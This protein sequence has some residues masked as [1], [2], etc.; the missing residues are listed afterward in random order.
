M[1]VMEVST[2]GRL[3]QIH[4]DFR[5][6]P[7]GQP[8]SP[9]ANDA[10]AAY[11]RS[12]GVP[13][14]AYLVRYESMQPPLFYLA[15]GAL[16]WPF[17]TNPEAVLYISKLTAA[18]FGAIAI[19]FIWA[20][21]RQL[22]PGKPEL[23]LLV[24]VCGA[25]LP[26]FAYGSAS[27]N[28]DTALFAVG[29]AS[30]YVW[31]RGLRELGYDRFLL[32]A[33]ALIGLGLLA[34]LTMLALVPAFALVVLFR[35]LQAPGNWNA[36]LRRLMLLTSTSAAAALAVAGWWLVRNLLEYGEI[37]GSA[38]ALKWYALHYGHADLSTPAGIANFI[39]ATMV[40]FIGLFGWD[41]TLF[42]TSVNLLAQAVVVTLIMLTGAA[43]ARYFTGR[44]PTTKEAARDVLIL[45]VALAGTIA[46]YV[47]FN[48]GVS[49]QPQARYL[50]V[51]LLPILLALLGGLYTFTRRSRFAPFILAALPFTLLL[52]NALAIQM[53]STG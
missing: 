31:L 47:Q 44:N 24:A 49:Y 7:S 14:G 51:A 27:A 50:F 52:L 10:V 19:Y 40:S 32:K 43:L 30:F 53:L 37:S 41:A 22:A 29:A 18:L 5:T 35:A 17:S 3:P 46:T 25:L 39:S 45:A 28:N 34:K 33:G 23:A 26:V 9:Y 4:Y 1:A 16:A 48:I 12:L 36:R 21:V 38:A 13:S 2:L 6:D 42:P 11:A 8:M 15:A 20:A